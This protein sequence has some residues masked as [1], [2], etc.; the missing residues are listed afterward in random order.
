LDKALQGCP[1]PD[2]VCGC[3]AG[4]V[5]AERA[6]LAKGLLIERF[7]KAKVEVLPDYAAALVAAPP[8][9]NLLIIAGTG[10]LVCSRTEAGFRK[11]G[12]GGYLIGDEAS[13]F[14]F[15]RIAL[16]RYI[17]EP[18]AASPAVR[19]EIENVFGAIAFEDVLPAIYRTPAP[20]SLISKLA[21]AFASDLIAGE[22]YAIDALTEQMKML[23]SIAE[24]HLKTWHSGLKSVNICLS[25]GVWQLS[26]RFQQAL[27]TELSAM[28]PN[29]ELT[30]SRIARP[31]ILGAVELAVEMANG[32]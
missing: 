17:S 24:Q 27:L 11:S 32:N 19:K 3:F 31:P 8:E 28:M 16:K 4:L 23:A 13:G 6:G 9:S 14:Q 7:P 22:Q 15:G 20:A 18:S 12:G 1:D 10:S 2:F 30:I 21:K 26:P 25:G 5:S 29:L